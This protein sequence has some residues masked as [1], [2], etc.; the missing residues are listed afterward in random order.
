M[1]QSGVAFALWSQWD[2]TTTSIW[3]NR[4]EPGGGWR[5]PG[6]IEVGE[7]SAERPEV[8][9]DPSGNAVAV[10]DQRNPSTQVTGIWAN[11]FAESGAV[12]GTSE[13]IEPSAIFPDVAGDANGN[14]V[15]VWMR[16][17]G[18]YSIAWSRY[19]PGG[20]WSE[21]QLL[22]TDSGRADHPRIAMNATG[23]AV[24]VWEQS[25]GQTYNIWANRY[26]PVSGWA[27][28]EPLETDNAGDAVLPQVA[29]DV[30][31]RALVVWQQR[32]EGTRYDI[33]ANYYAP[34]SGWAG[35]EP[36]ETDDSGG[37]RQPVV[38]MDSMGNGLAVW[39]HRCDHE[40]RY[41]VG[42]NRFTHGTGWDDARLLGE[43][44]SGTPQIDVGMSANGTG[45]AVWQQ[46][47]DVAS[48]YFTP[49]Y[50]WSEAGLVSSEPSNAYTPR[51]TLDPSGKALAIWGE[52][53]RVTSSLHQPEM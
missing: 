18:N 30:A 15:S 7:G 16:W 1:N 53:G 49:E 29:I 42:A 39:H 5:E 6:L 35:P 26:T 48:R 8:A 24:A 31:G 41:G 10:W 33:W 37:A 13:L 45:M 25:D 34:G 47:G 23:N 43:G 28:P 44:V 51:V 52:G 36:I 9:V 50:G 14:A 40:P 22:E 32:V 17:H 2:G 12:W 21:P 46:F 11:R 27:G 3:A 4:F 38:A 19:E 20:D